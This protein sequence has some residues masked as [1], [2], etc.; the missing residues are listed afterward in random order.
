MASNLPSK[1]KYPS[2]FIRLLPQNNKVVDH[3]LKLR[4][5]KAYRTE[6]QLTIVQGLKAIQALRN[7]NM[8]LRSVGITAPLEPHNEEAILHPALTV[9]RDP[10]LLPAEKY[11]LT[12]INL[13]RKLLGTAARPSNHEIWAEI[14][15]PRLSFPSNTDRLLVLDQVNDANNF[16]SIVRTA[17]ALGWNA[18]WRLPGTIDLFNDQTVRTSRGLSLFW[19]A[20]NG[21][22]EALESY[23]EDHDFTPIIADMVPKR[24]P[25]GLSTEVGRGETPN[26]LRLWNFGERK[27]ELPKKI[28][29]V[30]NSEHYPKFTSRIPE[31]YLRVAV[32]MTEGVESLGV[33]SVG[34]LLMAEFNR[35]MANRGKDL[36]EVKAVT[37]AVNINAKRTGEAHHG[38]WD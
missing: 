36:F 17:R 9:L 2:K 30:I 16:G 24:W 28:A 29:L 1:Y 11:Y 38:D 23:L 26:G 4:E 13:T 31:D 7:A 15:Y 37:G 14:P 10:D 35:V 8:P 33:T 6:Q 27:M 22:W 25:G 3:L 21:N 34:V 20:L 12:D 32:P 19:P 5:N 18:G